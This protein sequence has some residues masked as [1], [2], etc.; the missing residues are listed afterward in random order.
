MAHFG[1]LSY[2][3]TGHLNPLIA[4]SRHL[5]AR[6]HRVTFFQKAELEDRIRP[7]GPEF[8][9]IGNTDQGPTECPRAERTSDTSS[10]PTD[11]RWAIRRIIDDL[12]WFLREAPSAIATAG[13]DALIVDEIVLPGSTLAELIN[14]PYFVVSTSIPH[15]FGWRKPKGL[16]ETDTPLRR[17]QRR[18]LEVSLFRSQGPV[19]HS[20]DK[21]RKEQGLGTIRKIALTHPELAHIAQLPRC[22][23]LPRRAL[24]LTFHYAGPWVDGEAR[25]ASAFPWERLDGRR[26]IYASLGTAWKNGSSI[27]QRIAEACAGLDVQLVISLGGRQH[28]DMF[29]QLPGNPL[30][31]KNAPQ[32]DLLK[33]AAAVITHAGL[34]TA[35]EAILQAK[36]MVAI[37]RHFDQPAVA[38]RLVKEGVAIALP[39]E[40]LSADLVRSALSTI[41]LEPRYKDAALKLQRSVY[42][43]RGLDCAVEV[44]EQ[45]MQRFNARGGHARGNKCDHRK[46]G[47]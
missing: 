21:Y 39:I 35:L 38:A 43:S 29:Q 10:D 40:T 41:L 6:G 4:L 32:L 2:K 33:R 24:P 13:V 19:Q 36:P 14:L 5:I 22:L 45:S 44:I 47:R 27:F 1:V 37:P 16:G 15:R 17:A 23:D 8:C 46:K 11:I 3:G 28:P 42:A 34:N 12:G 30:V 20:L 9:A 26:L 18:S 25:F 7:F 31:V